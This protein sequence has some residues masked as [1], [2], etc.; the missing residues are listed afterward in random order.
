MIAEWERIRSYAEREMTICIAAGCNGSRE[1]GTKI[2]L[3]T[4]W[5]VSGPLG[6]AETAHKQPSLPK[7]WVC[8][9]AGDPREI[10]AIIPLFW[11]AFEQ[12]DVV[13]ET[14]VGRLIEECLRTRL[15]Q[16]RDALSHSRFSKPYKEVYDT[17]KEKLPLL[18][19]STFVAD[20]SAVH[21][22]AEFIIT[23]FYNEDE[24]LIQTNQ[25]GELSYPNHFACIGEGSYLAHASLMRREF[26]SVRDFGPALYEIYEAKKAA[27]SVTSVGPG[28]LLSVIESDGSKRAFN[29]DKVEEFL[30]GLYQKYGPKDVPLLMDVPA[31]LF[32]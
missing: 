27:E 29:L 24:F 7:G 26:S 11:N 21:L 20:I 14:N 25:R 15:A 30:D 31:T 5:R 13:D 4:D 22:D 28:T 10:N 19:F 23:G 16:K 18:D 6:S 3:C 8:L 32:W 2:I 17:G 12:A 9:T 1:G